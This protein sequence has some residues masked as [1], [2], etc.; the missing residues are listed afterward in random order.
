MSKE[1]RAP[2]FTKAPALCRH[3]GKYTSTPPAWI[4]I[5]DIMAPGS[6][7]SEPT[8]QLKDIAK[9][10][11]QTVQR[12]SQMI[13]QCLDAGVLEALKPGSGHAIYRRTW[14]GRQLIGRWKTAGLELK[15]ADRASAEPSAGY[16]ASPTES[17]DLGL[18]WTCPIEL[19][20]CEALLLAISMRLHGTSRKTADGAY[21]YKPLGEPVDIELTADLAA[22]VLPHF[23]YLRHKIRCSPFVFKEEHVAPLICDI[24]KDAAQAEIIQGQWNANHHDVV[25]EARKDLTDLI[26]AGF[27]CRW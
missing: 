21:T 15:D 27:H 20:R 18:T 26:A 1:P 11:G 10:I 22:A 2:R 19:Q 4:W 9:K 12:T 23:A 24:T 3:C 13:R 16:E 25:E 14:Y 6:G 8:M 7:T 5:L 17:F